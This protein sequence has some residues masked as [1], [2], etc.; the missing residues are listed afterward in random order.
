MSDPELSCDALADE[1][2]EALRE[3]PAVLLNA[4][5]YAQ[6]G[7]RL[8][9]AY[10]QLWDRVHGDAPLADQRSRREA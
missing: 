7:G 4:E 5:M 8:Q 9:R 3:H 10:N 2:M 6:D 1:L